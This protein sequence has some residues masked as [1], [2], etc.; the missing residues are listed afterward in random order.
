MLIACISTKG[1]VGKTSISTNIAVSAAREG[2]SVLLVDGDVQKSSLYWRGIRPDDSIIGGIQVIG[3]PTKTLHKDLPRLSETY[4]VIIIDCGGR[5]SSVL[6]SAIIA[7]GKGVVKEEGGIA[8]ILSGASQFDIWGLGD[9]NDALDEARSLVDITCHLL[10]NNVT[11]GTNATKNAVTA[12]SGNKDIPLLNSRI[13]SRAAIK[14]ASERGL[15]VVEFEPKGK[16]A[17]EIHRLWQ[18][19]KE[20]HSDMKGGN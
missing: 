13:C 4:D 9:T 12:L 8:L 16:A 14:G 2:R 17:K 3:L 10:I 18:E 19:L 7:C 5:D 1:G 11:Q 6:R 15:G 20:I